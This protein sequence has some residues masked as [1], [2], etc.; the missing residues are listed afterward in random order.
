MPTL[1]GGCAQTQVGDPTSC[2]LGTLPVL[3]T[4]PQLVPVVSAPSEMRCGHSPVMRTVPR[5]VAGWRRDWSCCCRRILRSAPEGL[6]LF[7]E[8]LLLSPVASSIQGRVVLSHSPPLQLDQDCLGQGHSQPNFQFSPASAHGVHVFT[9]S[10]LF[11]LCDFKQPGLSQ[12]C[13]GLLWQGWEPLT[14]LPPRSPAAG[15]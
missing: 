11:P 5:W 14:K 2:L 15:P 4:L 13:S 6:F 8:I 9:T 1:P 7:G 10:S 3:G 12:C